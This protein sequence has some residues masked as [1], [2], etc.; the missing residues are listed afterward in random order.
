MFDNIDKMAR[1]EREI[2]KRM[3]A[4]C[5][6]DVWVVAVSMMPPERT[7]LRIEKFAEDRI[8][9]FDLHDAY[10]RAL[11]F[12]KS[13]FGN[14]IEAGRS[15]AKIPNTRAPYHVAFVIKVDATKRVKELA[16]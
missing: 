16:A 6:Q 10:R 15:D 12:A 11:A 2:E 5:E 14:A 1:I 8:V 9:G 4:A 13:E 3:E 7:V